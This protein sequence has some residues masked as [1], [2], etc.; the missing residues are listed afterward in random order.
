MRA[1]IAAAVA[2]LCSACGV[3]PPIVADPG[4][5]APHPVEVASIAAGVP[6]GGLVASSCGQIVQVGDVLYVNQGDWKLLPE[7]IAQLRQNGRIAQANEAWSYNIETAADLT[8]WEVAGIDPSLALWGTSASLRG[9]DVYV[10]WIVDDCSRLD[11]CTP[12]ICHLVQPNPV[13]AE[14]LCTTA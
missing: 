6:A 3:V 9:S 1:L 11:A 12:D 5:C 13:Q 8:V 7:T 4:D 14:E 10:L 2:L